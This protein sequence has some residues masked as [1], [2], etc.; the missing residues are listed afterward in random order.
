[1]FTSSWEHNHWIAKHSNDKR[2]GRNLSRTT[3]SFHVA[4]QHGARSSSHTDSN[5]QMLRQRL[6][7]ERNGQNCR[8]YRL[9]TSLKRPVNRVEWYAKQTWKARKFI[10]ATLTDLCQIKN[11]ELEEKF[12]KCKGREVLRGDIVKDDSRNHAVFT[13]QGASASHMTAAKGLDVNSRLHGCS[14]QAG[15]AVSAYTQVKMKDAPELHHLSEENCPKIWIRVPKARR[16]QHWET[17]LTIQLYRWSAIFTVPHWLDSSRVENMRK[18]LW[19]KDGEEKSPDGS[20]CT[21]IAQIFVF[22]SVYANDRKM[23]GK[24]Q[25][26]PKMCAKLQKRVDLGRPCIVHWW[27]NILDVLNEQHVS[28]TEL[29]RKRKLS[30]KLISTRTKVQNTSQL[31]ATTWKVMLGSALNAVA[32]CPARRLPNKVSTSCVDGHHLRPE[33][34]EIVAEFPETWSQVQLTCLYSARIGRPDLLWTVHYLDGSVTKWNGACCLRLAR[35]IS[36][37]HHTTN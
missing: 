3:S 23:A 1:M 37:I 26:M 10:F 9:G 28:R 11:F 18:Q 12:R 5:E 30:S 17:Q 34:L 7:S 36:Y 22:L 33:D 31:G 14:G 4:L 25:N 35:L 6:F 15:D 27:S 2:V 16:P 19:K 20:A 13:E 21:F 29:W 32:N 8:S 24:A